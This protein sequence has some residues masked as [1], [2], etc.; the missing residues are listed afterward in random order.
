M[1]YLNYINFM[2]ITLENFYLFKYNMLFFFNSFYS[3]NN[4]IF[5]NYKNTNSK[6]KILLS[7]ENRNNNNKI[8]I[9]NLVKVG[10]IN[11]HFTEVNFNYLN[12][13]EF[14]SSNKQ[15]EIYFNSNRKIYFLKNN[16]VIFKKFSTSLDL[17]YEKK[18]NKVFYN[19]F[20]KIKNLGN[21]FFVQYRIYGLGFKIKKSYLAGTRSLRFEIGFGHGIYYMLPSNVKCL[22]RKRRFFLF[23]DNFSELQFVKNHINRFKLLNPYKIRGLKDLKKQIKMKKGKK[24]SKK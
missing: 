16:L 21:F 5:F 4:N 24:Q 13:S 10:R 6:N 8:I 14:V 20:F 19:Y 3:Y 18:I 7:K 22:K 2:N 1:F 15:N 12:I 17:N 23:S 9:N 11:K